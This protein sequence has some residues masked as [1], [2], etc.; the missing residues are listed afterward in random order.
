MENIKIIPLNKKINDFDR[1]ILYEL[2]L[3]KSFESKSFLVSN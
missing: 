1:K 2:N 3:N